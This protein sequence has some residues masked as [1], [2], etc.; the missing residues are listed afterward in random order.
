MIRSIQSTSA[1]PS[2]QLLSDLSNVIE[3]NMNCLPLSKQYV[4][5]PQHVSSQFSYTMAVVC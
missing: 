1:G 5:V 3:R 2:C 4:H